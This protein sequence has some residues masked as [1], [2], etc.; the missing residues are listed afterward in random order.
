MG[1]T[2]GLHGIYI[3]WAKATDTDTDMHARMHIHK[4][5]PSVYDLVVAAA[6]KFNVT[7]RSLNMY[8]YV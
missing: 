7:C 6:I 4:C 8:V 3:T 1:F 5:V 2:W